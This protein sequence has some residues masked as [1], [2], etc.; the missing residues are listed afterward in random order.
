MLKPTQDYVLVEKNVI[1]Q[2]GNVLLPQKNSQVP[3]WTVKA[4]GPDCKF[5]KP[6]DVVLLGGLSFY[7]VPST[8]SKRVLIE[9]KNLIAVDD[10]TQ[11]LVV[12]GA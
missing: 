5:I 6:N 11:E 2:I 1:E 9:E 4:V 7:E 12:K 3:T 10:G 8:D